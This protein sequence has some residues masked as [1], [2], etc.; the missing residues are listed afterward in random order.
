MDVNTYL[1]LRERVAAAGYGAERAWSETVQPPATAED[2]AAEYVW[3]VL[4]SGIKN[5]VAQTIARKLWPVLRDGGSAREV[6]GHPGKAEAIDRVWQD[7]ER[8][9]AAFQQTQDLLGFCL[10]LPWIGPITR[11][12]LAKNLGA[13]VAKPDRWLVRVA[14]ASGETVEQLCRRL[15][16][17]TGDRMATVDLV[18]WRACN[19]GIHQI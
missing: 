19:L 5:Q 17:A 1:D 6:F 16:Q 3:V 9:F 7:R 14:A 15:A 13:D 11:W 4:N 10:S 12:H 2:F 18:I 8:F